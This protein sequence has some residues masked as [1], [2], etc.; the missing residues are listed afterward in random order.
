MRHSR[1]SQKLYGVNRNGRMYYA[2]RGAAWLKKGEYSKAIADYRESIK[3]DTACSPAENGLAWILA[4]C[5]VE[6]FRDGKAAVEHATKASE[7]G[8]GK[9]PYALDTL[10]AALGEA[11]EFDK[12]AET[13]LRAIEL[14]TD[15]KLR[16]GMRDRLELYKQRKPFR[17]RAEPL[18]ECRISP[19]SMMRNTVGVGGGALAEPV[20]HGGEFHKAC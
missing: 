6:Q 7:L 17:E 2:A 18:G 3:S 10:A 16:S 20:A 8:Q 12:A 1:I 15:D 9:D 11:G 5:P 13:Q 19:R 14:I 4:T